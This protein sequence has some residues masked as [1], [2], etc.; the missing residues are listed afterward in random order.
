MS[1]FSD[2]L[3][4]RAAE[5]NITQ[6][7]L[8]ERA[9]M[10][11]QA[12]SALF[13]GSVGQPRRWREIAKVLQFSEDEMRKIMI[14]AGNTL[15]LSKGQLQALHALNAAA[16][17]NPSAVEPNAKIL[18][19]RLP[20]PMG[21]VMLPVLGEAVG[22]A[23]GEYSFN[24]NILDYVAS[25]PSLENVPHAYC[26][27][28]DGDSMWPRY[29]ASDTV[30]V[31]PSKPPRR[32]DDVIVQVRPKA[33]DLPPLGY[34]KEFVGWSASKLLLRQFNPESQIEF[35]RETVISVHTVVFSG[36]Y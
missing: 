2:A 8:A 33:E 27:Y 18:P 35:D 23:D 19:G 12:V 29:K 25:P 13:S 7:E 31:H 26:V 22:G 17:A 11:Q 9:G 16:F 28:V 30:Y 21:R 20:A 14:A 1:Q 10:S 15:E 3:A 6:T 36:K 24:G 34:I 5:L 4:A 32:G